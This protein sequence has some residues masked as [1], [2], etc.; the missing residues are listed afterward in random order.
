MEI[1][2]NRGSR[3]VIGW[4]EEGFP[5]E[6]FGYEGI[7]EVVIRKEK[8]VQAYHDARV[9][10]FCMDDI[11]DETLIP[12]SKKLRERD[13]SI[14]GTGIVSV[15][16]IPVIFSSVNGRPHELLYRTFTPIKR[17][18]SCEVKSDEPV[19]AIYLF[20]QGEED[21]RQTARDDLRLPLA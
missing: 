10:G 2:G 20:G 7:G 4:V 15:L 19:C 18:S 21:L 11:K 3:Y 8:L 16:T 12:P 6:V 14:L 13:P 1:I 5:I 17:N 9:R